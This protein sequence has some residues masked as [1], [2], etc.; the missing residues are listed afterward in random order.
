MTKYMKRKFKLTTEKKLKL[1][2]KSRQDLIGFEPG[3][4]GTVALELS[5]KPMAT[6]SPCCRSN[7]LY[8]SASLLA[9]CIH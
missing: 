9:N 8:V 6:A 4:S 3:M 1:K 2:K 5:T 7:R